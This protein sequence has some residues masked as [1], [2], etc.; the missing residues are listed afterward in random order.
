MYI[1]LTFIVFSHMIPKTK[2]CLYIFSCGDSQGGL[3]LISGLINVCMCSSMHFSYSL[4]LFLYK[5]WVIEYIFKSYRQVCP[6]GRRLLFRHVRLS[7]IFQ[8]RF[9]RTQKK[10]NLNFIRL[11]LIL[12]SQTMLVVVQSH[13]Y[14]VCF[15]NKGGLK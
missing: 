5:K 11:I 4:S 12:D 13:Y 9:S 2:Y 8:I 14:F 3:Q 1:N 15:L 10:S 6:K 7:R